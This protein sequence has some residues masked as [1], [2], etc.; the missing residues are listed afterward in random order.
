MERRFVILSAGM[1]AGHDA[2]AAE[3]A[4]RLIRQGHSVE[5]ADVLR[6]LP[7]G[8]GTGLRCFYAGVVGHVPLV[9]DAI[10]RAFFV[11]RGRLRGGTGP[12]VAPAALA[13]ARALRGRPPV[14]VISTFHLA[15]QIAGRLR[16][17]GVL[18]APSVVLITDFAVHR[19]WLHPGNDVHLC[20]TREAAGLVSR[21]GGRHP[22]QVGPVVPP[23]FLAPP[24]AVAAGAY[25]R[26]FARAAPDRV[27]VL[28][29]SGA[30]GVGSRLER[31]AALLAAA[32]YL[33]VVLCGR[34]ERLRRRMNAVRG[35]LGLGWVT[36]MPALLAAVRAV[37]ENAAGQTAAQALAA[38]VPVVSYRPIPGHGAD[39]AR[40]MAEAGL[41]SY[42]RDEWELLRELDVLTTDSRKRERRVAA[43]R[44]LFVADAARVAADAERLLTKDAQGPAAV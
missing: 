32:G 6:M 1:G 11:P 13:L 28:V 27:P 3:L 9:Y 7:F 2:V 35:V 40:R 24:D 41:T 12:V 44:E 16:E 31:T 4:R 36:D 26:R 38:G 5:T 14:T 29:S 20:P 17:R 25:E 22:V 23:A 10:Y 39:G 18:R 19:Q 42:A 34:N 8:L 43:G 33:P 21:R 15:A 37:V 30:W